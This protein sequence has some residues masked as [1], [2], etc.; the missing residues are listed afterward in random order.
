M[1]NDIIRWVQ[2]LYHQR[3]RQHFK[4]GQATGN[5]RSLVHVHGGGGGPT[6]RARLRS[7]TTASSGMR[8]IATT[9]QE[10]WAKKGHLTLDTNKAKLN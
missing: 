9:Y 7:T 8:R 6:R 2:E 1:R 5:K 3:R 4:S 10:I